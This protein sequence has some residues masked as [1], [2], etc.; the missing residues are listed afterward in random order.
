M[1]GDLPR[2]AP[3]HRPRAARRGAAA[4]AA[5]SMEETQ[6]R[7]GGGGGERGS[8]YARTSSPELTPG[9]TLSHPCP[10]PRHTTRPRGRVAQQPRAAVA[11]SMHGLSD[12]DMHDSDNPLEL[13]PSRRRGAVHPSRGY[14]AASN[15]RGH[16]GSAG[17]TLQEA[18][19][20]SH[21]SAPAL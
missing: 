2:V 18:G 21:N 12:S 20:K 15:G 3:S 9:V 8:S 13:D 11:T 17:G 10:N 16:A 1:P 4:A 19:R 14:T 6:E 5:S 7:R